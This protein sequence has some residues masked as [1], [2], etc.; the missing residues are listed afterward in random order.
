M[1]GVYVRDRFHVP[2]EQRAEFIAISHQL[3]RAH[4]SE[5][6]ERLGA[7]K[8]IKD[9]EFY[10]PEVETLKLQQKYHFTNDELLSR[11]V[12]NLTKEIMR[13]LTHTE[14]FF[15]YRHT[16]EFYLLLMSFFDL[17]GCE[18]YE[19]FNLAFRQLCSE[20]KLPYQSPMALEVRKSL[21][22]LRKI[23]LSI[24]DEEFLAMIPPER[25]Q[26]FPKQSSEILLAHLADIIDR[27][28]KNRKVP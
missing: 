21:D 5:V 27:L 17:S 26:S 7:S 13:V 1:D 23:V 18:G 6:I 11:L 24:T 22:L 19:Q 3:A 2:Q 25:Q 10:D 9:S 20:N 28:E 16:P 12:S 8:C 4:V 15:N 14:P